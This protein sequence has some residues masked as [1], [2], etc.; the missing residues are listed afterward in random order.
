MIRVIKRTVKNMMLKI[1]KFYMK[2]ISPLKKPCCRYIPT[3]SEYTY[4]A[5]QKFGVLR[6]ILLG[7]FRILRCT[8]FSTKSGYDPVPN[9]F[10]L[11][12]LIKTGK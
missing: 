12:K 6:G 1:I 3:C 10:K 4:E 5:I 2:F 8:P 9:E 11:K 7:I